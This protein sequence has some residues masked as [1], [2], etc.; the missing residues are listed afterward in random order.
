MRLTVTETPRLRLRELEAA[1]A[2]FILELLTDA[3]FRA[4]VGDRG[5]HD[6]ESARRYTAESAGASY[7]AHG[8]GLW[9]I[10]RKTDARPLGLC[11]LL[12]RDS[13]PDTEL[14]FALLP[15]ARRQGYALEA[16]TATLDIAHTRFALRRLVAI[17]A[18]AN[19][20]SIRLLERLAF[21]YERT[22]RFS[23]DGESRLYA[24]ENLPDASSLT[25]VRE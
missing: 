18:P 21:R 25:K 6:L 19:T 11:G 9:L 20:A 7:R 3:D 8:F 10:E 14:G 12:R 13:H 16:A 4:N 15:H 2:P 17:T 22:A 23:A 1:D 5:V 24:C